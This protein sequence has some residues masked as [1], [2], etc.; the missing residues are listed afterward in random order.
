MKRLTHIAMAALLVSLSV[1]ACNDDPLID[2]DNQAPI[3]NAGPDQTVVDTDGSGSEQVTLD[4]S[5]SSDADGTIASYVWTEGGTSVGT[6]VAPVVTL[7]VGTHDITLTVTDNRG[8]TDTD[9]VT[10][11]V[12]PQPGEN[13]PPTAEITEPLDGAEINEGADVTF[14]G[15]GDDAEDGALTGAS[16]VWTSDLDGELG[17]GETFVINTLGASAGAHVITLTATDSEGATG[18][19]TVNVT[20]NAAP[21]VTIT[22]P[23]DA[24][25]FD[26]GADVTFT[27]G[28]DDAEDG[29]LTDASLVWTS[30]L[31]GEIG[32]GETFAIGTLTTGAHVITLTATDSQGATGTATVNIAVTTAPTAEITEPADESEFLDDEVITFTGS[33]TDVEDGA[34]TDAS[35]V[36]TSDVDGEIGTGE[37]F[38]ANAADLT[39]G[40]HVITLTAT[41]SHGATGTATVGITI[42]EAPVVVSFSDNI[43]PYFVNNGCTVCHGGGT[44]LGDIQLDTYTAVTTGSNA[45]GDLIVAGDATQGTL[46]PKI[47]SG[48]Q[49]APHGTTIVA[50]LTS[51]INDGALE[52]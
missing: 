1:V 2:V 36:W 22:E 11:T 12:Q 28:A 21:V 39:L 25:V 37:T 27:G 50:D 49:G 48:H 47:E 20:I 18:T 51:W 52:N 10:I 3:A 7:A 31:D 30:D 6:G 32:T 19:A 13:T 16:L 34:L 24:S 9:G 41:D 26:P 44:S 8:A 15:S 14:T 35:L 40:A 17:T 45:N 43:L 46:I 29:A 38:D 4:G 33:G 23:A 5:G 42:T